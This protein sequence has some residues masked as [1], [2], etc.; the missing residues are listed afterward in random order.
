MIWL[1]VPAIE[2]TPPPVAEM[3]RGID[4]VQKL[5]QFAN[6]RLQQ[7]DCIVNFF[8]SRESTDGKTDR[9]M[10]Q[11]VVPTQCAMAMTALS[12]VFGVE[13]RPASAEEMREAA[14]LPEVPPT[15]GPEP[16]PQPTPKKSRSFGPS[17]HKVFAAPLP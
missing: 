11:F 16:V 12:H 7:I 17:R 9:A 4:E 8:F 14:G 5:T 3:V 1:A 6:F 13:Y 2:V 15:A 10:R